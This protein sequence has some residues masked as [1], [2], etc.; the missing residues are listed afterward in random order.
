MAEAS[1]TERSHSRVASATPMKPWFSW[2]SRF[3]A[4]TSQFSK[5]NSDVGDERLPILCISFPT[6]KP[7]KSLS[8]MKPLIP[9]APF[10]GSV[11]ASTTNTWPV[12]PLVMNVLVPLRT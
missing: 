3:S 5:I 7:G 8:M 12:G 4:G 9:A 2:P 6:E 1:I 10:S 11:L